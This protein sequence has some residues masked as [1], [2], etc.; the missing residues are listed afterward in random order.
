[1]KEDV[2]LI[3]LT[4]I[5]WKVKSVAPHCI[6]IKAHSLGQSKLHQKKE[7]CRNAKQTVKNFEDPGWVLPDSPQPQTNHESENQS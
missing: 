4:S 1:M 6:N 7:L 5:R 2:I 3:K